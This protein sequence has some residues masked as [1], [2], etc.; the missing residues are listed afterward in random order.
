LAQ[1]PKPNNEQIPA[2]PSCPREEHLS[3]DHNRNAAI[4]SDTQGHW[5]RVEKRYGDLEIRTR[6]V[7][8]AYEGARKAKRNE[9]VANL[10]VADDC[11]P[12][13]IQEKIEADCLCEWMLTG[14]RNLTD[15][16]R[17]STFE[18]F[19]GV[20][21][22]PDHKLLIASCIQAS[23]G[24]VPEFML[25]INSFYSKI[26]GV[27]FKNYDETTR[28]EI[29]KDTVFEGMAL[30]LY[31]ENKNPVDPNA[32][33]LLTSYGDQIG[34]LRRRVASEVRDWIAHGHQVTVTV[35]EITGGTEDKPAEGV[36]ILVKVLAG[37]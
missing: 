1:A 28:Q 33:A 20:L 21:M 14:V 19:C 16:G 24:S 30:R 29:I 13:G 10:K 6:G 5:V 31:L 7:S 8:P 22:Q 17:E 37:V 4:T 3:P 12:L 11:L 26:A 18:E 27:S 15:D 2:S 25:L 35:A 23:G 34:Y 9:A 36:N 32:V